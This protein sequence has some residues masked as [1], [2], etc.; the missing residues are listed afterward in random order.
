M[1]HARVHL[2]DIGVPAIDKK[3]RLVQS[4]VRSSTPYVAAGPRARV[5]FRVTDPVP[6][7]AN[8]NVLEGHGTI[9]L[10]V[11]LTCPHISVTPLQHTSTD[12]T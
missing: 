5:H 7:L 1:L 12:G 6:I 2:L 11:N 3:L 4:G 9:Q 8:L 10:Q